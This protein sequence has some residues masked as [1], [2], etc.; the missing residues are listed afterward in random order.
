VPAEIYIFRHGIESK[1]P[2][3]PGL[4]AQGVA[5]LRRQACGLSWLDVRF[6]LILVGT[7][8]VSR[9]TAAALA[10]EFAPLPRV[11][12]RASLGPTGSADAVLQ[13]LWDMSDNRVAVVGCEP[14]VGQLA[15][16]LIGA[17]HPLVFKKAAACRI[18]VDPGTRC[19]HLRWLLP[20]KILREIGR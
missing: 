16:R 1:A 14:M 2:E 12:E 19:G 15:A 10:A 11:I 7:D 6:D 8:V 4:S 20:P 5:R 3:P 17:H 9:E 13:E 18:D